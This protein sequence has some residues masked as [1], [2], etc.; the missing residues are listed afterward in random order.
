LSLEA[1]HL[2]KLLK[3]LYLAPGPRRTALRDDIRS[4]LR[5]ADGDREGGDFHI[6]FW[7][8]AKEHVAG[9]AD[10]REL[11]KAR[12]ERNKRRE[13]LYLLLARGFLVWWEE[14]RR[15]RNEPFDPILLN[16]K[17]RYEIL[18]PKC[19][20]KIE[21]V[22]AAKLRDG[23][24]RI[25]YPY[26]SEEPALSEEAARI[27]LWILGESLKDHR[28]QDIRI[29]DVLRSRSFSINDCPFRGNEGGLLG[30][31]YR[32]MHDEWLRLKEQY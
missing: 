1:I 8:D 28:L 29:L 21:N 22:L 3:I 19:S 26:F 31:R 17:G 27:G 5:A 23:T 11:V 20:I 9:R 25:T 12:I 6:P 4:D 10:L 13:R 14:R 15:W 32:Q 7:A 24:E 16:V 18:D 2:R 30:A